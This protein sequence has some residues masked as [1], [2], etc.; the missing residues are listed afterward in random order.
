[1]LSVI[2]VSWNTR[3]LLRRCLES[4]EASCEAHPMP[5]EIIVVDNGSRDGTPT[6]IRDEFPWVRLLEPGENLGFSRG[7]NLGMSE[8]QGD[9]F[10]LLNPD[11]EVVGD[12]LPTLLGFLQD[13]PTV[14]VVGPH[15]QYGDGTPQSTRR[16]FPSLFTL[17]FESTLFQPW[18]RPLLRGYYVEDKIA[19]R[20]QPVDWLMGAALLLRRDL[21]ETVG[22][23]DEQ[24]FMY[25]E[26]TDWQ[27]RIKAAGWSI[28]YLPTATLVHHEDASS[29][30]VVAQRHIRFNRSR[31]SYTA[32][33]HGAMWALLLR[34]WLHLLFIAEG[35]REGLKWLIGHKRSLRVQRLQEYRQVLQSGL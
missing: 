5:L 4:I 9:H 32:K 7:S 11:T 2:I 3:E 31:I 18:L 16:R 6:M 13:Y 25:F 34:A 26:E 27:R 22:G 17:F 29:G 23:L 28:W 12:A 24:F 8:A 19:G 1:M 21:Y 15:L 10:L 33:W 35:A 30:Q 14:G 20:P